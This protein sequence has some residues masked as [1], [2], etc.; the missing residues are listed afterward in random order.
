LGLT[1]CQ[2]QGTVSRGLHKGILG[3]KVYQTEYSWKVLPGFPGKAKV[4]SGKFPR[5]LLEALGLSG[6][7]NLGNKF[8]PVGG[9]FFLGKFTML[10]IGD[11]NW[12]AENRLSYV[13]FTEYSYTCGGELSAQL[14]VVGVNSD[15]WEYY[16]E[17]VKSE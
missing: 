14:C 7:T 12:G 16:K 11:K 1:Q 15:N 8:S 17:R 6:V 13:W 10:G 4:H 5:V 2:T 3:G 9:P